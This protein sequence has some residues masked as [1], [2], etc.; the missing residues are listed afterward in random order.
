MYS[1][2]NEIKKIR[3]MKRLTLEE[4]AED[5]N[6]L[7]NELNKTG[8]EE[9]P[10]SINKGLIS[11]W[12][13]GKTEPRMDTIRLISKWSGVSVDTLLGIAPSKEDSSSKAQM[14]I[15]S[16]IDENASEEEIE[17]IIEFIDLMK[18]RYGDTREKNS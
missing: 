18:M 8:P 15:A 10:N 7:A 4:M 16:H 17:R 14:L 13:N 11:R 6:R 5:L 9:Y 1:F 3:Q 12:E 2:A